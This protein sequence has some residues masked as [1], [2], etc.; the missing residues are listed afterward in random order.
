MPDRSQAN[1]T[2]RGP[3]EVSVEVSAADY[4]ATGETGQAVATTAEAVY[5]ALPD[6]AQELARRLFLRLVTVS[7]DGTGIRRRAGFDELDID[8]PDGP[9]GP[10]GPGRASSTVVIGHAPTCPGRAATGPEPDR[11]EAL[12][13]S[14][15]TGRTSGTGP[16]E[17][18]GRFVEA[19]LLRTDADGVQIAH[20]ALLSAWPRLRG[21]VDTEHAGRVVLRQLAG[22]AAA[23]ARAGEDPGLLYRTGQL[24]A[25]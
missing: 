9:G 25:A 11:I 4:P 23:W 17:I 14:N 12:L 22:A 24:A 7:A 10:G 6:D 8:G 5:T 20:E 21:W 15:T 16:A 18:I 1:T 19:H 13:S 2:T 3:D